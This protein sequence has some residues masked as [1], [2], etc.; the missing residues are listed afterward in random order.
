MAIFRLAPQDY[1]RWGAA[2][3]GCRC[4]LE[5]GPLEGVV[6]VATRG[7]PASLPARPARNRA[8]RPSLPCHVTPRPALPL[9]VQVPPACVRPGGKHHRHPGR[10]AD[11]EPHRRQFPLRRRLHPQQA[12]RAVPAG[13]G[14]RAGRLRGG[15]GH[16]EAASWLEAGRKPG[17]KLGGSWAARAGPHQ[18]L[19]RMLGWAACCGARHMGACLAG[20]PGQ[21]DA[22]AGAALAGK[23]CSKPRAAE[24]AALG[25]AGGGQHPLDGGG[26]AGGGQR[27]RG[28][29]RWQGWGAPAS[30]LQLA[31]VASEAGPLAPTL[32]RRAFAGWSHLCPS[33][34]P[35]PIHALPSPPQAGYFAFGGSTCVVLFQEGAAVWDADLAKNRWA[36]ARLVEADVPACLTCL[37]A[38]LRYLADQHAASP[39]CPP[40]F[41]TARPQPQKPGDEGSDGGT[42][43]RAG[44][45]RRRWQQA[46]RPRADN[47]ERCKP[48]L[49]SIVWAGCWCLPSTSCRCLSAAS[50]GFRFSALAPT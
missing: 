39:A 14:V 3:G 8:S 18:G 33:T 45:R 44:E 19:P 32:L 1:H 38:C 42:A 24:R 40:P 36:P 22:A 20:R 17:W 41:A 2:G 12:L 50:L 47:D 27:R 31:A 21:Y 16:G 34:P 4:P 23:G 13:A 7:G 5:G 43:G 30:R 6:C 15:G 37:P 49:E 9:L 35:V 29:A 48:I 25:C 46:L 11:R 26:G 10:A 28:E